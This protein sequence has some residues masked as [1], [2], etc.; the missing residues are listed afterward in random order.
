MHII[1][2]GVN[3]IVWKGAERKGQE[4]HSLL[5]N[6]RNW[7]LPFMGNAINAD[8]WAVV[9]VNEFTT[10]FLNEWQNC[11]TELM[12]KPAVQSTLICK[13]LCVMHTKKR[14]PL[15]LLVVIILSCEF[16]LVLLTTP[17]EPSTSITSYPQAPLSLVVARGAFGKRSVMTVALS[18]TSAVR[19]GWQHSEKNNSIPLSFIYSLQNP[20]SLITIDVPNHVFSPD[21]CV[22]FPLIKMTRWFTMLHIFSYNSK[23]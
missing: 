18:R 21:I 20:C 13:T 4:K 2:S 16:M 5:L 8:T 12:T 15:R 7:M 19:H 3:K 23:S 17:Q 9:V 6:E 22:I 10:T 1:I 11:K 14:D